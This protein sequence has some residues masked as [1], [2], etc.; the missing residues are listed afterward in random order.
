MPSLRGDRERRRRQVVRLAD[1]GLSVT[2]IARQLGISRTTVRSDLE[3]AGRWTGKKT[4]NS[5]LEGA[6]RPQA[7]QNGTPPAA[8]SAG[9]KYRPREDHPWRPLGRV[10]SPP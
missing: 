3:A 8:R 5:V 4:S 7:A 10:A 6:E 9:G 1:K 2:Q